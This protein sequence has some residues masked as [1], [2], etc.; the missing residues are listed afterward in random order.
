MMY[1]AV[2]MLAFFA[3]SSEAFV[4]PASSALSASTIS[5]N[6]AVSMFGGAKKA[7]PKKAAPKKVVKKAAPKKVVKKA[8][9]NTGSGPSRSRPGQQMP[10]SQAVTELLG[11]FTNAF[12]LLKDLPK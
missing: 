12:N 6:D 11:G 4:A 9:K 5:R 3:A 8:V 10:A 1:R 2:M 7:A